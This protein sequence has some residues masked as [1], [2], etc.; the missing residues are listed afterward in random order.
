MNIREEKIDIDYFKRSKQVIL[1]NLKNI[2]FLLCVSGG[3]IY[4]DDTSYTAA[5][6]QWPT[7]C[8]A[9]WAPNP[10]A[11]EQ[12]AVV[13]ETDWLRVHY[14]HW[15]VPGVRHIINSA[16]AGGIRTLWW[17]TSAGGGLMYPTDVQE[18]MID[19]SPEWSYQKWDPFE[20]AVE[21]A[22]TLGMKIYAWYC[23]LEESHSFLDNNRSRFADIHPELS[24]FD[25]EGKPLNVPSYYY[26]EYRDYKLS[27]TNELLNNWN[28]DGIV[29]DFERKGAPWR[30]NRY[31]Y[32]P[33]IVEQFKEQ[34]GK[35]P[36]NI[37]ADD[38]EWCKFRAQYFEKFVDSL[39]DQ[40]DR[41]ERPFSLV[42]M[43]TKGSEATAS[44]QLARLTA[45]RC[46]NLAM[47]SFGSGWPWAGDPNAAFNKVQDV[48]IPKT[49]VLYTYC[50]SPEALTEKANTAKD[51]GVDICWFETTPLYT[52][53][54]YRVPSEMAMAAEL[55][56][57]R[58]LTLDSDAVKIS[59][60]I[61]GLC[62]WELKINGQSAADGKYAQKKTFEVSEFDNGRELTFDISAQRVPD[63]DFRG[64][65]AM[66]TIE[67]KDGSRLSV[68]TDGSWEVSTDALSHQP[69]M[70]VGQP[71][72]DPFVQEF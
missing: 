41:L 47:A 71:G 42:L 53:N 50:D 21:Y 58:T 38:E 17:R 56:L 39:K 12:S 14:G 66:F 63:S 13:T 65:A 72:A 16:A 33:E 20:Y 15:G 18:A 26:K 48:E 7:E 25:I 23:P 44:T 64:I 45:Q 27:I 22:H 32:L 28:L 8:Y 31:D 40:I 2:V 10:D 46:D 30:D 62:E 60:A 51:I 37:P 29:L 59:G 69:A 6:E 49:Y 61:L 52:R 19:E 54:K 67:C 43:G 55:N 24:S 1:N 70:L 3:L 5:L 36:Y 34:T 4:A 11:P 57:R 68:F 35:D 9:V